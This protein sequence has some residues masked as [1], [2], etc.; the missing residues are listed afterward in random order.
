MALVSS[1]HSF[2]MCYS[3][4]DEKKLENIRDFI[5]RYE[6]KCLTLHPVTRLAEQT[7][8]GPATGRSYDKGEGQTN[9]GAGPKLLSARSPF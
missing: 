7:H 8:R 9:S 4:Q 2:A 6:I 3:L 5:W 1:S